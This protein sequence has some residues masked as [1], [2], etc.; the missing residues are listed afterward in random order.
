MNIDEEKL[1]ALI[2]SYKKEYSILCN[3]RKRVQAFNHKEQLARL[4][5]QIYALSMIKSLVIEDRNLI[6][7]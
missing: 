7:Q 4:E 5:G 1:N 2:A 6:E 3:A